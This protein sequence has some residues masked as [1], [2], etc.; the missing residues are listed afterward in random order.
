MSPCFISQN[1]AQK[2]PEKKMPSTAANAIICSTKL[3]LVGLHHLRAQL[4]L[5]WTYG[6]VLIAWNRYSFSFGS[7]MYVSIRREYIL[8]WLFSTAIWKP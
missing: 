4:A 7:L 5:G 2:E 6:I 3:A 8:L 1:M